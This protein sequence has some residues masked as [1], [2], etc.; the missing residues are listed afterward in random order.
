M[1]AE[2]EINKQQEAIDCLHSLHFSFAVTMPGA[3]PLLRSF[4][5]RGADDLTNFELGLPRLERAAQTPD[6][7]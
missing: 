2:S 6:T 3:F 4:I 1:L 7:R 5:A